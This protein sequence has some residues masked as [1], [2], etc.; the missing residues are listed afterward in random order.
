MTVAVHAGRLRIGGGAPVRVQSMLNTST[1]DTAASVAQAIR[2]IEA[3]GELVRATTQ[4]TREALNMAEIRKGLDAAGYAG[5][6]L[7]ADVHFNAAVADTAAAIVEKVRV[8]PGNYA[9]TAEEVERKFVPFLALCKRHHTAIRIGVNHGSLSRRMLDRYG[10]TPEGMVASCMEF[11]RVCKCESFDDVVLSVKASNVRVMVYT[12]RQLVRAMDEEDMHYPL[13]LG[14]TEAGAG[15]DGRV[16]SAAG[17]GTLLAEGLGDTIR[18]S[19]SEAP[20]AEIPVARRLVEICGSLSANAGPLRYERRCPEA[21]VPQ[22]VTSP[23]E[24]PAGWSVVEAGEDFPKGPAVLKKRYDTADYDDFILVASAELGR[25]FLDGTADGLWIEAP[26]LPEDK[27]RQFCFDLLQAT[28][29]RMSKT[30]YISCPTCGRTLFDMQSTLARI[31]EA[32]ASQS[33]L[34]IGVMG[35]IVNGPGEMADADYGYVGAGPGRV[36]LYKGAECVE[37]GIP[38]ADAVRRLV[39]LIRSCG[40]WRGDA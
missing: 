39:E 2:I 18:V 25:Y 32:T 17:I 16:K 40:D 30:E 10:D 20:E 24:V 7:V 12:V 36:S 27:V 8:N 38:E 37:R 28:R 31:K 35:C 33:H 26:R 15:E 6:P 34:K 22:V 3:G 23:G 21:G 14:V 1:N 4:G 5:V 13:H 19:L 11:L 29:A 9:Q